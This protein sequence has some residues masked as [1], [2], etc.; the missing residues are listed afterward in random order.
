MTGTALPKTS[1]MT[2]SPESTAIPAPIIFWQSEPNM[3]RLASVHTNGFAGVSVLAT[4]KAFTFNKRHSIRD[5][6]KQVG[7]VY[8]V[9]LLSKKKKPVQL[10][11]IW[12]SIIVFYTT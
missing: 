11:D 6:K 12:N 3:K 9:N 2:L 4:S 8:L 7:S 5:R 10:S 1:G